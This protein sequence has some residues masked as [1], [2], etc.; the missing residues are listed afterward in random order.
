MSGASAQSLEACNPPHAS[1]QAALERVEEL[2]ADTGLVYLSADRFED[3]DTPCAAIWVIEL[4]TQDDDVQL[5]ILD[6]QTLAVIRGFP[7]FF[8]D[9]IARP[10]FEPDA[11]DLRPLRIIVKG[12]PGPDLLEGEWSD[13]VST[14]GAGQDTF[15]LTP[16]SDVITDFDPAEDV[17][18]MTNF[19]FVDYGFGTL[20]SAPE[21]LAAARAATRDGTAGTE[22]D[23]DGNAGD[24]SV[25]LSGL[26]PEALSPDSIVFPDTNAPGPTPKFQAERRVEMSDGSIVVLPGHSLM[27]DPADPLLSSGSEEALA[28]VRRLFFFDEFDEGDG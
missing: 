25:F 9:A 13:D 27:E 23:L 2:N 7:D 5:L 18:N 19:A 17:L 22:I 4:L 14:G 11:T 12:T 24:W 28:L 20:Q 26:A 3:P 21:V 8:L 10:S 1:F 16:G 6:A 15:L